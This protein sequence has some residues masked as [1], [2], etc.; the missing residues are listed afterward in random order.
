[1][2]DTKIL[3]IGSKG[4]LGTALSNKYSEA[5]AVDADSLDITNQEQLDKFD[6]SNIE[7]VLN[8][9]AYTNVDGAETEEGRKTAWQVNSLGVANLAGIA[10][11][12][13][14]TLVHISTDYVF[15]GKQPLHTEDEKFSPLSVYGSTKAA[16]DL[17]VSLVPKHYILRTSWIIGE[18]HNFVRTMLE[19]GRKGIAPKVV[20]DQIGRLTFTSELVK[21]IDHLLRT[22]PAYGTYNATNEGKS[23]SWAEITRYIFELANY[24]LKVIDITTAIYYTNKP[25]AAKRPLNSTL[26][27]K[28][29]KQ[30]G[31]K[32]TN[33]EID[34]K[35][36]VEK[37]LT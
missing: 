33:W 22:K 3:I 21:V 32:P 25:E 17:L 35:S 37:E 8:V 23:V 15:D 36:Y 9:A 4:Q 27:L 12:Y 10:V 7:Y 5:R 34:L 29:L 13:D 28:K 19:V 24:E 16:A 2:D 1:M 6:F 11:K 30:T 14:L 26:E 20:S 18:G 31:F